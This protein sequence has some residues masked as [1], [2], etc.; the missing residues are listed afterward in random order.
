MKERLQK[1]IS[2][3][4]I[5]ARRKAEDMIAQGLV[6][7]NGRVVEDTVVVIDSDKDVVEIQGVKITPPQEFTI[8][9]LNKPAGYVSTL[10]DMNASLK[11]TDLVPSEPRVFPVGRLDKDS[12]GLILLTNNGDLAHT[13]THPS[14]SHE[15]EYLVEVETME[16][17]SKEEV[18]QKIKKLEMGI[19]I[20]GS[21][22][23]PARIKLNSIDGNCLKLN[24]I[25]QEG[26]K[27]QIRR[28]CVAVGFRVKRLI[29][30]RIGKL[31]LKGIKSGKHRLVSIEE[32]L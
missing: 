25:L 10:E 5:A 13:L 12:E 24:F 17:M 14:F 4:G 19:E 9:A 16:L 30:T 11:V 15:K 6:K 32:I 20:N 3:C 27:R 2:R 23:K 7:V 31:K 22:T 28:M 8:Y 21:M 18:L 26:K 29:R 1:Y